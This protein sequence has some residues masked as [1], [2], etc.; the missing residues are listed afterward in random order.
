MFPSRFIILVFMCYLPLSLCSQVIHTDVYTS[1]INLDQ[2]DDLSNN[3]VNDIYQD[4]NGYIW[5]ATMDGLNR[6]DG[7]KFISFKHS[8]NDSTSIS[9][10]FITSITG[11]SKGNIWVGTAKGLNK[12]NRQTGTFIRYKSSPFLPHTLRNNHVRRVLL[13]SDSVLW[14]ETIDGTLSRLEILSEEFDHFSHKPISQPD[15]LYHTLWCDDNGN[16]W[17]G[18][19]NIEIHILDIEKK[20]IP[21]DCC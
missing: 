7:N 6:F 3:T 1:F 4:V 12:Y 19:R 21:I 14:A 8:K 10:N 13:Q 17:I 9:D 15:Y 11:D 5:I 18:G 2:S 20:S 16:I